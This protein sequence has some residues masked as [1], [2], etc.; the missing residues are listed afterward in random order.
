MPAICNFLHKTIIFHSLLVNLAHHTLRQR[1]NLAGA[2][3]A[4]LVGDLRLQPIAHVHGQLS[5]LTLQLFI[6]VFAA[7]LDELVRIL[8][9]SPLPRTAAIF[10]VHR[11]SASVSLLGVEQFKATGRLVTVGITVDVGHVES[12]VADAGPALLGV[13]VHSLTGQIFVPVEGTLGHLL[14]FLPADLSRGTTSVWFV[15]P[16]AVIVVEPMREELGTINVGTTELSER[17]TT[18]AIAECRA[19]WSYLFVGNL[20]TQRVSITI[21]VAL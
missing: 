6:G 21:E 5:V 2:L 19:E 18:P 10:V 12:F 17:C 7:S 1:R 13:H 15:R 20:L 16:D 9:H 8:G 4:V 14:L 3:V 11:S